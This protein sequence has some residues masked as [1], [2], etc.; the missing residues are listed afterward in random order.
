LLQ[1]TFSASPIYGE[2]IGQPIDFD[3]YRQLKDQK[4]LVSAT[5]TESIQER[6]HNSLA[7]G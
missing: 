7:D 4:V 6:G 5:A 3:F 2:I 1:F